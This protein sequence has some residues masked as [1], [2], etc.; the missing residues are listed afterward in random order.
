[1]EGVSAAWSPRS[2]QCTLRCLPATPAAAATS[3]A[4]HPWPQ[5]RSPS[6]PYLRVGEIVE[7]EGGKL[8]VQQRAAVVPRHLPAAAAA[9]GG[10]SAEPA[11]GREPASERRRREGGGAKEAEGGAQAAAAAGPLAA[12]AGPRG[13]RASRGSRPHFLASSVKPRCSPAAPDP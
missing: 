5:A 7:E 9:C 10:V 2:P 1:M 13:A 4:Q 6:W 11:R 3:A 8:F 12:G